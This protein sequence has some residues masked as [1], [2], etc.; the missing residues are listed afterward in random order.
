MVMLFSGVSDWKNGC[1]ALRTAGERG[2]LFQKMALSNTTG[3][4]RGRKGYT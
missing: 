1:A 4:T 3:N 2:L